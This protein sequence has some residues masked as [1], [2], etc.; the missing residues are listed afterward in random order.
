MFRSDLWKLEKSQEFRKIFDTSSHLLGLL[1]L[2]VSVLL[3]GFLFDVQILLSSAGPRHV[4]IRQFVP[5]SL[6]LHGSSGCRVLRRLLLGSP[7]PVSERGAPPPQ[8]QP[9]L[10]PHDSAGQHAAYHRRTPHAQQRRR[11]CWAWAENRWTGTG[12]PRRHP[13]LYLGGDQPLLWDAFRVSEDLRREG[14]RQRAT[15]HP[16]PSERT[17]V[18]SGQTQKRIP[19]THTQSP[20]AA[21]HV[22]VGTSEPSLRWWRLMQVFNRK[23]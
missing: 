23:N 15:E 20:P 22:T 4:T 1:S 10:P 13:G 14:R 8:V 16:A 5:L 3:V 6:H 7:T 11:R 9:L 12:Q 21:P 17:R 2:D 19:L 18:Q